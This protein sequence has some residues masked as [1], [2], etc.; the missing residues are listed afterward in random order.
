M[1]KPTSAG[2]GTVVAVVVVFGVAGGALWWAA[3]EVTDPPADPVGAVEPVIYEVETGEVGRTIEF[4]GFA[5]WSTVLELAGF[6]GGVVT[7]LFVADGD[8]VSSGDVVLSVDLSPSV[9]LAGAV[10][11]FRRIAPGAE[12]AD[13]AQLQQFLLDGGWYSGEVDGTFGAGTQQAIV[14]WQ[15]AA[16]MADDG[17]VD[18]GEV[19]FV[20][21]LPARVRPLVAVGERVSDIDS[22]VLAVLD[23]EPDI[24]TPLASQQQ[25]LIPPDAPLELG[26]PGGRSLPAAVTGAVETDSGVN[27]YLSGADEGVCD[28]GCPELSVTERT[29]VDVTAEIVEVTHGPVVPLSAIEVGPDGI[30][31][32]RLPSGDVRDIE[33]LAEDRGLAVVSG[34]EPGSPILLHPAGRR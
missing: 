6:P 31:T 17:I 26:L 11:A 3:T 12:G 16:G 1:S 25:Q 21:Q 19:V 18:V 15:T 14:R 28:E 4:N 5:E 34:L 13:V 10:P 24:W 2:M 32:I 8:V 9:V 30:A 7:E 23:E 22:V 29:P 27:L 33:I 20:D